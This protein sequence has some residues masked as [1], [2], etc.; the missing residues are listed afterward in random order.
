MLKYPIISSK[1]VK[2]IPMGQINFN[3]SYN[4]SIKL[5]NLNLNETAFSV[6]HVFKTPR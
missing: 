2:K 6:T 5:D 4:K 1:K 3:D